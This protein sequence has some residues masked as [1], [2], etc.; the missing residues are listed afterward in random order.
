MPNG[1]LETYL[2]AQDMPHLSTLKRLDIML[3]VSMALQY[4]HHQH[5]EVVLHCDFK[6]INVLFDENMV[7][8]VAGFGIAKLL[9][10]EDH[11]MVSASMPGTIL[12]IW[13]QVIA[14]IVHSFV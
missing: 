13:H 7:A 14:F 4:L 12:G 3:D 9:L 1:S 10:G 11:S 6:T 8:H 5:C 2:H